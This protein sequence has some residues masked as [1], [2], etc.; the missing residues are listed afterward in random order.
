MD[1][2]FSLMEAGYFRYTLDVGAAG[3]LIHLGVSSDDNERR[4]GRE[5]K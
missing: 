2:R 4:N 3:F 5:K 1:D